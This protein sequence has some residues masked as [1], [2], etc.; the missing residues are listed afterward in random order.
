MSFN[1][2]ISKNMSFCKSLSVDSICSTC[3]EEDTNEN[4]RDNKYNIY[5][6]NVL[7][8]FVY[9]MKKIK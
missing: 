5:V 9:S 1:S 3:Y 4:Y 7:K 2:T 8:K 6:K